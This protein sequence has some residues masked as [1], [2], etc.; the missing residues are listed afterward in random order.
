MATALKLT[1]VPQGPKPNKK[2]RERI[3]LIEM[4]PK[5]EWLV[6]TKE[7]GRTVWYLRFTITGMLPRRFGPFQNRHRALLAL[8]RM[9]DTMSDAISGIQD[10]ARD[11]QM[12]RRFQ[13]TWGPVI[14]D[15][16]AL[17]KGGR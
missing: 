5:P 7:Q 8:D 9:L 14:E 11:Y 6:S 17:Q 4:P 15:D 3:Q 16:L 13:Q 2:Q 10:V 12:R 1:T